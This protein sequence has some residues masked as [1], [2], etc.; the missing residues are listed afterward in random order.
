MEC[1][2]SQIWNYACSV[3][4]YTLTRLESHVANINESCHTHG[5][6]HVTDMKLRILGT[7]VHF[8]T[9]REPRRTLMSH[10]TP[11]VCVM[12]QIWNYARSAHQNVWT[13]LE[14]NATYINESSHACGMSQIKD[15]KSWVLG[16]PV[17]FDTPRK[18]RLINTSC[19]AHGI[20]HVTVTDMKESTS[21]V[22]LRHAP[23]KARSKVGVAVC[24]TVL[25]CRNVLQQ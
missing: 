6:R 2:M 9:P 18:P 11:M 12:S 1:A 16:L 19:H 7:R 25:C 8:D 15:M 3:R 17:H 14:S 23:N 22:T 13:R 5:M 10:V 4:Q 20:G 24:V 21:V